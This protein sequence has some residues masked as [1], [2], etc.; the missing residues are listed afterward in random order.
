MADTPLTTSIEDGDLVIR[1][2]TRTL[3]WSLEHHPDLLNERAEPTY[4]VSDEAE[5]A[6]DVLRELERE[7]EDGTTLVHLMLDK[8]TKEALEQGSCAVK[9]EGEAPSQGDLK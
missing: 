9:E 4:K 5:F 6:K 2:G 8:A 1:I 3:A 7:E